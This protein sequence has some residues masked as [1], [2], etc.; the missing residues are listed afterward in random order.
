[1]M[2]S[3]KSLFFVAL[4]GV[5]YATPVAS[6]EAKELSVPIAKAVDVRD[7]HHARKAAEVYDTLPVQK[8]SL[9]L[10]NGGVPKLQARGVNSGAFN[11]EWILHL[12]HARDFTLRAIVTFAQGQVY[13]ASGTGVYASPVS[14]L[15]NGQGQFRVSYL[16][17]NSVYT[18]VARIIFDIAT[19]AVLAAFD[20]GVE[21]NGHEIRSNVGASFKEG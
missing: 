17:A 13:S 3:L 5:A 19:G 1:M 8:R 9:S 7:V 11:I 20:E 14:G 21:K 15:G 6:N 10:P 12:D 2:V 16:S 4:C 18:A